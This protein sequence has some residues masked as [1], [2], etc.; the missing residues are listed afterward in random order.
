MTNHNSEI[1]SRVISAVNHQDSVEVNVGNNNNQHQQKL[2]NIV[3]HLNKGHSFFLLCTSNAT[4]Q[5]EENRFLKNV[6][7]Y[8]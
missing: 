1:K 3:E 2:A 6:Q 4:N 8:M 5:I 7:G